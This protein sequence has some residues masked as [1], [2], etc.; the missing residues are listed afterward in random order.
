MFS[1]SLGLSNKRACLK[2]DVLLKLYSPNLKW[3]DEDRNQQSTP[4]KSGYEC[5]G[6]PYDLAASVLILQLKAAGTVI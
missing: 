1:Q 4:K 6:V 3:K 5:F 2:P